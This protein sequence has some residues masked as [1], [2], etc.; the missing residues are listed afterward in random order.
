MSKTGLLA[1][2]I[3]VGLVSGALKAVADDRDNGS[4]I[5]SCKQAF[6]EMSIAYLIAVRVYTK[7]SRSD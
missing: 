7:R 4:K 3:V 1:S 5:E 2:A 6:S